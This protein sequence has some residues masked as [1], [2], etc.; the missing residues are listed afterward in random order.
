MSNTILV[1]KAGLPHF[2]DAKDMIVTA[3]AQGRW[4]RG[5]QLTIGGHYIVLAENQ[6]QELIH[7]LCARVFGVKEYLATSTLENCEKV[8]PK[9]MRRH[10]EVS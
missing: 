10:N 9:E 5:I 4:G 6:V 3:T 7:I 1:L 8:Y 2:P